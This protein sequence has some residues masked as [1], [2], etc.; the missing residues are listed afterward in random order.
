[1]RDREES[2]N[3]WKIR[4]YEKKHQFEEYGQYLKQQQMESK[5]PRRGPIPQALPSGSL[6]LGA[7]V[8]DARKLQKNMHERVLSGKPQNLN[9]NQS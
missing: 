8:L 3:P 1:M 6:K 7:P 4:Q 2:N 5:I 9:N